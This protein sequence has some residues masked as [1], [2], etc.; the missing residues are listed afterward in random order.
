MTPLDK[1]VIDI[2]SSYDPVS[3]FAPLQ[4]D[5]KP[6]ML[7][8]ESWNHEIINNSPEEIEEF[9]KRKSKEDIIGPAQ[10]RYKQDSWL[11]KNYE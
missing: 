7:R 11:K 4:R 10:T 5:N 6:I 9:F 2:R 1:N 8:N 3:M